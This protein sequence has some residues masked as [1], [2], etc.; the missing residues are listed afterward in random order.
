[1]VYLLSRAQ[2]RCHLSR[3]PCEELQD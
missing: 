2:V 1:M 3:K